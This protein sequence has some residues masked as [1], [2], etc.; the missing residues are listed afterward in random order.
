MGQ[1]TWKGFWR[2]CHSS[3]GLSGRGQS[4]RLD[5]GTL[6]RSQRAWANVDLQWMCLN[7]WVKTK[8][9]VIKLAENNIR[10]IIGIEVLSHHQCFVSC[11]PT[12]FVVEFVQPNLVVSIP[13]VSFQPVT[14]WQVRLHH[15]WQLAVLCQSWV[16]DVVRVR[17]KIISFACIMVVVQ[18]RGTLID[19]KK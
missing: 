16:N 12:W 3:I 7:R 18:D 4:A 6:H 1:L 13:L 5:R 10:T 9:M 11:F 15:Y 2:P 14:I 8:A 17:A 19:H